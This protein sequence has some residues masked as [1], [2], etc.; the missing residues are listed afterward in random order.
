MLDFKVRYQQGPLDLHATRHGLTVALNLSGRVVGLSYVRIPFFASW[1]ASLVQAAM[2]LLDWRSSFA[3]AGENA[4]QLADY[5]SAITGARHSAPE[6][7]DL[8]I[9]SPGS[10]EMDPNLSRISSPVDFPPPLLLA[11][12]ILMEP[13][14]QAFASEALER[15][16]VLALRGP[17]DSWWRALLVDERTAD[18]L[19][20]MDP[21]DGGCP[22][23]RDLFLAGRVRRVAALRR[24][25]VVR[26]MGLLEGAM[27]VARGEDAPFSGM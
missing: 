8:H 2:A 25:T 24:G 9:V 17:E 20:V 14:R 18:F 27:V 21:T 12:E 10:Q 1:P 23:A 22:L 7:A 19:S 5:L 3:I 13:G 16:S 26:R 11:T 6:D 4:E 15:G